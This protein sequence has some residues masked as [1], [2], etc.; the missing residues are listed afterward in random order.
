M[1]RNTTVDI[2]LICCRSLYVIVSLN[3]AIFVFLVV[4]SE[5]QVLLPPISTM[6]RLLILSPISSFLLCLFLG[7]L[8]DSI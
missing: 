7:T 1:G 3:V 4:L 8:V 6:W 5:S 2:Q